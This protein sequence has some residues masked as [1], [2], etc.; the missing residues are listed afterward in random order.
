MR[1]RTNQLLLWSFAGVIILC[2][3]V[4]AWL[5]TFITQKTSESI[6]EI[7]KIYVSEINM[8]IQ[9]KFQTI[10]NLRLDQ[11][12][13]IM[14][15]A[16]LDTAR[17]DD[18]LFE[19]IGDRAEST[20]FT[21]LGF[22]MEDGSLTTIYGDDIVFEGDDD[23]EELL[24]SYGSVIKRG[25]DSS[26]DMLFL[27]GIAAGYVME[28]GSESVAILA[29]V[30]MGDMNNALYL[31]TEGANSYSHI[32]NME[33]DFVIK[34]VDVEHD[35]YFERI[36]DVFET[37]DGVTSEMYESQLRTA[38]ENGEDYGTTI[39]VDGEERYIYCSPIST[40]T[41][42]YLVTVMPEGVIDD[43]LVQLDQTRIMVIIGAMLVILA[44]ILAV[45]LIYAR[46]TR[47]N[48]LDLEQA[49]QEAILANQ[50][51]S[52]FL[53]SMSHDIRTPMNAIMGM[54]TIALD[55]TK[56]PA[57]V[58]D[59]LEKIRLSGRHLLGLINDVLDMSKIESGKMSMN[60]NR[61]S[62]REMMEDIVS[63]VQ[64]QIKA[65]HQYFDIYVGNL[66]CEDIIC[67]GIR[68]NQVLL[69]LLSNA[70]KFTPAEGRIDVHIWQSPSAKGEEY[71]ATQFVVEDTGIG[72][73]KEFQETIF[74]TFTR[75]DSDRVRK[76]EGSGLG[77][78][79]TKAIVDALGGS[80][81]LESEPD[82]GSRFR[83]S[84]D[85]KKAE[86][87]CEMH[88]PEWKVLVV[89][90]NEELCISAAAILEELGVKAEWTQKGEEAL[91]RIAARHEQKDEYQFV[92]IDWKMPGMD[93]L[94]TIRE[95]RDRVGREIPIFLISAYDQSDIEE[96]LRSDEI[97][98]FIPKPLF[99]ST[100]YYALVSYADETASKKNSTEKPDFSG[101]RV[102]IAE[103][104]DINWEIANEIMRSFGIECDRA[105]NGQECVDILKN[106]DPGF[107]DAVLMDLQMPVMN[108]MEATRTIRAMEG[109]IRTI[110]IIAM[111]A[112][113]FSS[114]VQDCLDCGMN[115]HLAKPLDVREIVN[116][117]RK[118][119]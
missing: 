113:A 13:T 25:I 33:G 117:L 19:V 118:Y 107:Y 74:D 49:R 98:G 91:K 10:V 38:M 14:E 20:D 12:D 22:Y 111:T 92:L 95:I 26:G 104:I 46:M 109:P 58:E 69:N 7:Q 41:T 3:V 51:K 8:Q 76:T 88:L 55:N 27:F 2:I 73:S 36:R 34:N 99:K 105:E 100:L 18:S 43:T 90:D 84:L 17:D 94:Q 108:G 50:A 96:E 35:N 5:A 89:D 60:M 32:I 75:E 15:L 70:L 93:G 57:R 23:V 59:C 31:Y 71:V 56:D 82:H 65:N 110:P 48:L 97:T 68:L 64:P 83:I 81:E 4:F 102:L 106:A 66:L 16:D 9:Q 6:T 29:G 72:M 30:P 63:I 47:Q 86:P 67:D 112:N 114:D 52:N 24:D 103:D 101:K 53:S 44:S 79:I 40:K 116:V 11:V 85:L 21:Y 1:K 119:L 28:D 80:I 62:L 115:A 77:M 54:T 45:F 61:M 42:W 37:L 39:S 78:A 87:E